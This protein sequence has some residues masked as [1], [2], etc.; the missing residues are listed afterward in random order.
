M[1]ISGAVVAASGVYLGAKAF[2][3]LPSQHRARK[4]GKSL[5]IAPKAEE[6][7]LSVVE[8]DEEH[9]EEVKAL[10]HYLTVSSGVLAVS[11]GTLVVFPAAHI[12]AI[13]PLLY[14]LVP[15]FMDAYD[16]LKEKKLKPS[17]VDSIAVCGALTLGLVNNLNPF[18]FMAGAA[19]VFLYFLSAKLVLKT[20]DQSIKNLSN[21]FGEQSRF[22]WVLQDGVEIEVPFDEVKV[23]DIVI[24]SAGEMIPVDGSIASGIGSV[25]QRMLTGESQPVEKG[26]GESVFAATTLLSGHLQI[27]VEKAGAD[28]VAAQIGEIWSRTA[29]YKTGIETKGEQ[30]SN[31]S[32]IPTLGASSLALVTLGPIGA[33]AI[34]LSNFSDAIQLSAPLSTLNFLHLA[35]KSGI[36]IKD[37]RALEGLRDVDTVVFDKTGTLTLDEPHVGAIHLSANWSEDELLSFAA[38]TE[39]KQ[40]HPV[41]KAIVKAAKQRNLELQPLNEASY[42]VGYGIKAQVDNRWVRV[43]SNRFMTSEGIEIPEHIQQQLTEG[44]TLGYTLIMVAIDDELGGAITLQPTIRPE[45]KAMIEGLKARDLSLCIISGDHELPTKALANE[46]GIEQYFAETLPEDK[47]TLIAQLQDEGRKVC[48]IGDGIN[49]TIALKQAN[50]S[51]SLSGAASAATDTAQIIMMDG[52]LN[53]LN[54]VFDLSNEYDNNLR[55]SYHSVLGGSLLCV[56]GVFFF[57]FGIFSALS[58]QALTL[59]SSVGNAFLPLLKGA[60]AK[61]TL[62]PVEHMT[63]A[64][65]ESGG[66]HVVSTSKTRNIT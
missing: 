32:V 35:A 51:I 33:T 24:V 30:L 53:Y 66:E 55:N 5:V 12:I 27:T 52:S 46:L 20:K 40:S 44:H 34:L 10:N 42:E 16:G 60:D 25:D 57:H 15:M 9:D 7:S 38:A 22:A 41:A 61:P 13:P 8:G 50:V 64:E 2:G 54:H 3:L 37:G 1:I 29:D 17:L 62:T 56:G 26:V 21:L 11:L 59:M 14:T 65:F 18:F 36:L 6:K 43:G 31:K 49:D 45:A 28:A 23:G 39:V 47:A 58:L 4:K 19:G 63:D 48:F